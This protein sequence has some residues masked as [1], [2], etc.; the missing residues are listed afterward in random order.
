M[1][2]HPHFQHGQANKTRK[3]RTMNLTAAERKA[4]KDDGMTSVTVLEERIDRTGYIS[5]L[6]RGKSQYG[7]KL[8][9]W[10]HN[11]ESARDIRWS[12]EKANA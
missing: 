6:L 9:G 11:G 2:I 5:R 8:Y 4:L 3:E 7:D 12:L 10:W 1:K